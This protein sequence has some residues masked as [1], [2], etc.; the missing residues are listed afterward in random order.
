MDPTARDPMLNGE[1]LL[2]R[3]L[4]LLALDSGCGSPRCQF[5]AA[6]GVGGAEAF[7]ALQAFVAQLRAWGRR[8]LAICLPGDL[9]LTED[10]GLMLDAFAAAQA[11]DYR[12]LDERL[13]RL[14]GRD[15]GEWL[16]AAAC[17]VA[18]HFAMAG[19]LLRV[20]PVGPAAQCCA[21]RTT[22]TST[23]AQW[24]AAAATT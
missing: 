1:R 13:G 4:R 23:A 3:T 12:T 10:E 19:L 6:L 15:V 7:H 11:E 24:A 16:G 2:I 17:V 5:E 8:Q 21:A 14:A 9:R 22:P 20:A 18:Q